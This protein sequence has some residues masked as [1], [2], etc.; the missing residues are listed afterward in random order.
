MICVLVLA[1]WFLDEL[2]AGKVPGP[3]NWS[4][5]REL[6]RQLHQQAWDEVKAGAVWKP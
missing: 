5:D 6:S 3:Y 1:C 4:R 2:E